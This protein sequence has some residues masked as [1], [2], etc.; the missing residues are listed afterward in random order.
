MNNKWIFS[1]ALLLLSSITGHAVEGFDGPTWYDYRDTS[2]D[3][4][5]RGTFDNPIVISTPEQLAQLSYIVNEGSAWK[6]RDRVVV[7]G[8]DINLNKTVNGHRVQWIPIGYKGSWGGEQFFGI[9]LGTDMSKINETKEW[10]PEYNH[11]ISGMYIDY[12]CSTDNIRRDLGL[13]GSICSYVGNL[14]IKDAEISCQIQG[15]RTTVCNIGLLSGE[16]DFNYYLI[17][18]EGGSRVQVHNQICNIS[19]EGSITANKDKRSGI[20]LSIGGIVGLVY[21]VPRRYD[22]HGR[23]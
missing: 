16:T 11:T 5:R 1:L 17:P 7:L 13:F 23:V 21:M 22:P 3:V 20:K 2:L 10:K 14:T 6:L 8:A 9:F 12:K 18:I 15:S 19:V 4:E